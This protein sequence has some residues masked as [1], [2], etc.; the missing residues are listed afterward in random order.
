[1]TESQNV[2]FKEI[3]RDEYLK[4]ICGF[5]LLPYNPDIANTFFRAGHV[6]TW[7]RGI[8]KICESCQNHGIPNPEYEV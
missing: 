6:E 7:G 1:M 8:Q 4:W 5:A 2:E 3:W